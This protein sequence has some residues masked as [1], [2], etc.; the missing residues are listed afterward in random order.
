MLMWFGPFAASA[1]ALDGLLQAYQPSRVPDGIIHDPDWKWTTLDY[2]AIGV[3]GDPPVS[4]WADLASVPRLEI[5]DPER[6][7]A[8]LSILLSVLDRARQVDSDAE[9]GWAWWQQRAE[10]G[11]V[12]TEDDGSASALVGAGGASHALTLSPDSTPVAGLA[13][14]PH[15]IAVAGGS[16][17]LEATHQLMDWLTSE[18]AGAL[19]KFSPWQASSNGLATLLQSAPPLD[20]DWARQ[21]YTP[22]RQRWAQSGFGPTFTP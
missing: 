4:S 6:S 17:N 7:E 20:I 14:I 16:R 3:I 5:A 13:P 15:T 22:T 9:R 21:Q 1:A 2:S 11:L 10:A 19:L 18:R 12:L 8:G